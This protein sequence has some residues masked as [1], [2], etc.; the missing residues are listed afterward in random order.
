MKSFIGT[1][2]MILAFTL[3]IAVIPTE[4]EARIYDDT[5][6]LHILAR[7]DSD[8]DQRVKLEIRDRILEKY[9][10][11]LSKYTSAE[12]ARGD[13]EEKCEEIRVSVD[14]WLRELGCDYTAEVVINKE[15]YDTRVYEDFTLPKGEYVSLRIMLGGGEGENWWCVMF[16]PMCL[17]ASVDGGETSY[18]DSEVKLIKNSG[19]YKVKFKLLE[20][21]SSAIKKL[22][23]KG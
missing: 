16:P 20:L 11:T 2:A 8:D 5:V 1:V 21:A 23:G 22:F 6:R 19:S 7:S 13:L 10:H 15:W 14:E 17:G 3:I 4:T 12:D 18:S 9:S